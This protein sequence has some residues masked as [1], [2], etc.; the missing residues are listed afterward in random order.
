[1]GIFTSTLLYRLKLSKKG[2]THSIKA[3]VSS[4][5]VHPLILGTD[6]QGFHSLVLQINKE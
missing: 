1:M 2:K 6:C 3:A 5:L 4:R